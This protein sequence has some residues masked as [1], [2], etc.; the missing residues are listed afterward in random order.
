MCINVNINKGLSA[1]KIAYWNIHGIKSK[2]LENKLHDAEFLKKILDSDIVGLS[3][4]HTSEEAS[5]PGFKLVKQKF[6]E[7]FHKGPKISGGL[8]VFVK[9]DLEHV[10][11]PIITENEDSIWIKLKRNDLGEREDIYIGTFYMSPS[12]KRNQNKTDLFT[13][14]NEEIN[15]FKN[16]GTVLIQGDLNARTGLKEDFITHDKFDETF[17]IENHYD[18]HKRNSEDLVVN[19]RGGELLDFCKTNDYLIVNGRKLGDIF[20]KYTSHQWNGSSVVDYVLTTTTNIDNIS[21]FSIG[22]FVP[23]LSDHCPLFTNISLIG[24]KPIGKHPELI[25]NELEPGFTWKRNSKETY[26]AKLVSHV[27]K[28]KIESLLNL[29]NTEPINLAIEIKDILLNIAQTCKLKKN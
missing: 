20:G 4:L 6:R 13:I 5:L 18:K 3:E 7:K 1:L 25:L 19:Q 28:D 9:N 22:D 21:S 12:H 14:L 2:V 24:L 11:Q 23:W 8:A 10:V 27:I 15:F 16:K 26:E 29:D 17:G